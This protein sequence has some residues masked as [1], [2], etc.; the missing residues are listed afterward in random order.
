MK[1]RGIKTILLLAVTLLMVTGIDAMAQRGRGMDRRGGFEQV[2]PNIPDLTEQQRT[3]IMQLRTAHLREMQSFRDQIDVNRIGYRAL[4]RG[5]RTDMAAINA[6]IEERN[7]IR[8]QMEKK[9]AAHL[10]SIRGLLTEE[11]RSWFDAAPR[12]GAGLRQA[13]P[14]MRQP[15]GPR[16]GRG[17]GR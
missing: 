1:K 7:T 17:L 12:G 6:N 9:Q 16:P 3:Q 15:V 8:T 10:Q 2:C 4:M 5:E 14:G 11:Q 13:G